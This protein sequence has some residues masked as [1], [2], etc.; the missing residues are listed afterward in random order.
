MAIIT[1]KLQLNK[2]FLIIDSPVPFTL[3]ANNG[4]DEVYRM[5][6]AWQLDTDKLL[7][8]KYMKQYP[9]F[10]L[11]LVYDDTNLN[12]GSVVIR[13]SNIDIG[14]GISGVNGQD[15]KVTNFNELGLDLSSVAQEDTLQSILNYLP[16]LKKKIDT[17]QLNQAD[18]ISYLINNCNLTP[19]EILGDDY[20]A[21]NINILYCEGMYLANNT[22]KK[23]WNNIRIINT[24]ITTSQQYIYDLLLS[25]DKTNLYAHYF[26]YNAEKIGLCNFDNQY[27]IIEY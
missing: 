5:A 17:L 7:P 16:Q 14:D 25:E 6:G 9:V 15:V 13:E 26:D 8:E 2:K 24:S 12:G 23:V 11:D 27:T 1:E 18:F 21:C 3:R 22:Y 20:I 4:T 10:N 19:I